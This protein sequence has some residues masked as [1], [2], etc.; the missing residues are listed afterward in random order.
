MTKFLN[1]NTTK[2]NSDS[3]AEADTVSGGTYVSLRSAGDAIECG[4]IEDMTVRSE[5]LYMLDVFEIL[6][7]FNTK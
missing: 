6:L 1:I 3:E 2:L 7:G 4:L 5:L